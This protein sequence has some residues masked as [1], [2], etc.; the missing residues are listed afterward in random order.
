VWNS[1]MHLLIIAL[2]IAVLFAGRKINRR[3]PPTHPLPVT[4]PIETNGSAAAKKK[5]WQAVIGILRPWR[6]N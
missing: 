4:S 6:P 3:R 1:A 5:P 2:V